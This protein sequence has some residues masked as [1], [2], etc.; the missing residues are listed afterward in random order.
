MPHHVHTICRCCQTGWSCARQPC[1]RLQPAA[2]VLPRRPAQRHQPP[3]SRTAATKG[4]RQR[5]RTSGRQW[6]L[7]TM[8]FRCA[9]FQTHQL[10]GSC[11]S[12]ASAVCRMCMPKRLH[13]IP[14]APAWDEAST[15]R[16]WPHCWNRLSSG[17]EA[18]LLKP[19][20]NAHC[21]AS[22]R[23]QR[24]QRQRSGGSASRSSAWRPRSPFA[25]A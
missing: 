15:L 12:T 20:C 23:W 2:P 14:P 6:P 5:F 8:D 24:W 10:R 21:G 22:R 9:V 18:T 25:A 11:L 16:C 4:W 19:K 3:P 13:W 17:E 1:M 7:C